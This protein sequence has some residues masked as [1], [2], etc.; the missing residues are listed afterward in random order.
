MKESPASSKSM[1]GHLTKWVGYTMFLFKRKK[2]PARIDQ[3]VE[4]GMRLFVTD[5]GLV[6]MARP[7]VRQGD[8]LCSI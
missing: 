8:K 3:V 5:T 7:Q 2:F 4:K 1:F 6:G